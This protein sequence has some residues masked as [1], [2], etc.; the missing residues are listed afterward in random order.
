LGSLC[1]FLGLLMSGFFQSSATYA[2][3]SNYYANGIVWFVKK[4]KRRSPCIR[5]QEPTK[6][7]QLPHS[8]YSHTV[9]TGRHY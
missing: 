1:T 6:K 9:A 7:G 8:A 2:V 4:K 3:I 5:I